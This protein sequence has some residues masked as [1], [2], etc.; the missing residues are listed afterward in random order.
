MFKHKLFLLVLLTLTLTTYA[1]NTQA[2]NTSKPNILWIVA[3]D[4]SAVDVG[5]Y[6]NPAVKTPNIDR[7]AKQG[8][9]FSRVFTTGSACS[10]SRTALATGVYQ[11]TLGA[12]HMRYSDELMPELAEPVKILPQMMRENGYFTGNIRNIC[13]TGTGK[14]DWMFKTEQKKWDTSSWKELISHQPFFGQIHFSES[15]RGFSNNGKGVLKDKMTIPPYYPDHPVTRKDWA[16]YLGEV[17]I[18]DNHVGRILKQ[19]EEDGLSENTIV[20]FLSDHGRPMIRGKNWLYDSGTH[21]PMVIYYPEKIARPDKFQPGTVG[22]QL[23]SSVDLV[24][25]TVRMA[26]GTI[27]DWMQGRCFLRENSIPRTHVYTAADRFGNIDTCSRA[28]RTGNFKYIRNFKT[29]DSVNASSTAYRRKTH[30]IYHLLNIMGERNLLTPVQAQLLKPMA[31]EEL[32]D[33][34]NDPYETVNLIGNPEYDRVQ[35]EL[36]ANLSQWLVDSKDK[37]IEQDS[38][39]IV[40]HFHDYG[41]ETMKKSENAIAKTRRSV[42]AYFKD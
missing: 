41:T 11:T 2:A 24:A 23:L 22:T 5:C 35:R 30:P 33:L 31:A 9:R 38:P 36:S 4:M 17:I 40:R 7:L 29:P 18:A 1:V 20:V 21:V 16:G 32:Y 28:V 42:E 3:E 6:G 15:H 8:M 13:G 27:P 14:D 19:L 25:E 39:A 10:P 12:H 26:G 37:G 34:T